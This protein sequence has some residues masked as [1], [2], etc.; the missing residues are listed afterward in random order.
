MESQWAPYPR[1][2]GGGLTVCSSKTE[3]IQIFLRI[4]R[5]SW[6][7]F[8]I[9]VPRDT[10]EAQ[11]TLT[12][13]TMSSSSSNGVSY[14]CMMNEICSCSLNVQILVSRRALDQLTFNFYCQRR[15][16]LRLELHTLISRCRSIYCNDNSFMPSV[17]QNSCGTIED[18]RCIIP[19]CQTNCS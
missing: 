16:T 2:A 14:A 8:L 10:P 19:I 4:G 7:V 12:A 1:V 3:V 15:P 6:F 9:L 5:V 18:N 11:A 17:G 13:H